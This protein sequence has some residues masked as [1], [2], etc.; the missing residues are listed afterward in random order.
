MGVS[1]SGGSSC[2]QGQA[3]HIG[4][5]S[6]D[7]AGSGSRQREKGSHLLLR[8]ESDVPINREQLCFSLS[9]PD[10]PHHKIKA[11]PTTYVRAVRTKQE[12]A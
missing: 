9:F 6:K 4:V 12:N 1:D 3:D 8:I 2:T 5:I 11:D 7:D 10:Y